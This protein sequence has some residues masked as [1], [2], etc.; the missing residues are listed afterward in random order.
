MYVYLHTC[1][2]ICQLI[3]NSIKGNHIY[4]FERIYNIKVN[5]NQIINC[6]YKKIFCKRFTRIPCLK[7]I[8]IVVASGYI[9][10]ILR[11]CVKKRN[12]FLLF[13]FKNET[14]C[15]IL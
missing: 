4:L 5:E 2:R 14:S 9:V 13:P 11:L 7:H 1:I 15:S 10:L 3:T 8:I 6:Y 12:N